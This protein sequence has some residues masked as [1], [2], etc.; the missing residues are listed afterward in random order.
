M[1]DVSRRGADKFGYFVAVLE[2]RAVDLYEG[3]RV[4]EKNL[5]GR[6]HQACLP[7]PRRPEEQQIRHWPSGPTHTSQ[8]C[9]IYVNEF[10]YGFVLS[11]YFGAKLFFKFQ[12]LWAS[13]LGFKDDL[14]RW[15]FD[16]H[17]HLPRHGSAVCSPNRAP[18]HKDGIYKETIDLYGNC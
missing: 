2:F 12:N 8:N 3:Q 5:R 10:G 14:L 7:G 18:F 16:V 13:L 4:A 6:F 11:D 15:S 1:S 9:L 17:L